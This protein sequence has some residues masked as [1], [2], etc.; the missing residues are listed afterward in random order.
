MSVAFQPSV[1]PEGASGSPESEDVSAPED[2][3]PLEL[4]SLDDS[5]SLDA[6]DEVASLEA[7]ADEVTSLDVDAEDVFALEVASLEVAA[8]E[9]GSLESGSIDEVS[10][11]ARLVSTS[12]ISLRSGWPIH[13]VR[14]SS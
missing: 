12:V 1:P 9:V 14:P 13:V 2:V 11:G 5:V 3:S 4:A 7:A 6:A 10:P 8:L